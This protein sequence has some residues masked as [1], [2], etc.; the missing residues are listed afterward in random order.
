M[1]I[2]FGFVI[3]FSLRLE[4]P[5]SADTQSECHSRKSTP[6]A[7]PKPVKPVLKKGISISGDS[8]KKKAFKELLGLLSEK[9][10]FW[11]SSP[12]LFDTSSEKS[13]GGK[14]PPDILVEPTPSGSTGSNISG[15][16]PQ[17]IS[18]SEWDS[19]S[20]VGGDDSPPPT[21]PSKEELEFLLAQINDSA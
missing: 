19:M 17:D 4:A 5:I 7:T 2:H 3:N 11:R 12:A 18:D 1:L 21:P 9:K 13:T 14:R 15:I 16:Y 6:P 10:P 20:D 8:S